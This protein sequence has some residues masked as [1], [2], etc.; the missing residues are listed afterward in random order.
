MVSDLANEIY[1]SSVVA[2]RLIS[3]GA[4]PLHGRQTIESKENSLDL[5]RSY[6][7][8]ALDVIVKA[9]CGD[10]ENLLVPPPVNYNGDFFKGYIL[11]I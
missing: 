9:A 11:L 1:F 3:L 6:G 4:H 8:E 5:I 7:R 2:K 10:L